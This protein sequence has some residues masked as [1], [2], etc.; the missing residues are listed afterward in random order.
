MFFEVKDYP[1][2]TGYFVTILEKH[3]IMFTS[4]T[5]QCFSLRNEKK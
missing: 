3:Q 5:L 2:T 4:L 1:Y